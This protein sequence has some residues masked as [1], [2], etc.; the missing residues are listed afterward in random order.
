[1]SQNRLGIATVVLL[2]LAGVTFWRINARE[3]DEKPPSKVAVALP[4]IERDKLDEIE[5]AAPDKPK[6]R[7]VKKGADWRLAEPLDAKADQ[8]A[9]KGVLDK[10]AELEVTG[11]AATKAQN[12]ERLEVDPKKGTHVIAK[13]AGKP[14]LDAW[15]GTYQSGNSMLRV[16]GQDVV[17]TVKGSIRYVFSRATREW[18]DRNIGKLEAKDVHEMLFE[19]KNGRFDFV[20]AGEDWKQ[21]V[22]KHEKPITPLDQSKVKSVLGTATSLTAVDFAE[23][24]V[25]KEQ[26]GLGAGAATVML[27]LGGDG[28]EQQIIYRIGSEKDQNYY[29]EREGND[30]VFLVSSWIGGRLIANQDAFIKKEAPPPAE[31]LG[32]PGSPQNPIPVEPIGSKVIKKPGASPAVAVKPGGPKAAAPAPKAAAPTPAPAAAKPVTPKPAAAKAA[33]PKQ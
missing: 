25:T 10:L 2:V 31:N 27:K 8:D 21:V 4:K 19:N 20:R 12:H 9:V 11:V 7:L 1:M 13:A 33:A 32:P 29:L 23:P 22:G 28:A 3:A 24:T 18:R 16:Q 6:V 30:M 14:V 5:L 15:I 26:A 17:A